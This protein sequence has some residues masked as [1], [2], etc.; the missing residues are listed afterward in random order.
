[1]DEV[2][3]IAITEAY[4]VYQLLDDEAKAKIPDNL[5]KYLEENKNLNLG[6]KLTPL[7]PLEKQTISKEGWNLITYMTTF[8]K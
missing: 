4:R 8:L 3:Q 5:K 6:E 7:I 1:M 2:T